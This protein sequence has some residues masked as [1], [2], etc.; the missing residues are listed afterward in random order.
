MNVWPP[1]PG[2]TDITSTWSTFAA[3]S[4][5]ATTGVDGLSATPARSPRLR[6]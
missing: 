3:I 6:M 1:N 2:F 4:S 5:S